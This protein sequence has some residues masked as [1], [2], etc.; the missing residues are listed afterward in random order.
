MFHL[1]FNRIMTLIDRRSKPVERFLR[2]IFTP[3][4][5]CRRR[6][7]SSGPK[8]RGRLGEEMNRGTTEGKKSIVRHNS[9]G[10]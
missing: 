10:D 7:I 4:R 3:C 6:R 9:D 1:V 8:R 5:H 2:V